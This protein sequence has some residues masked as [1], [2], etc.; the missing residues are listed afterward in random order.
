MKNEAERRSRKGV[1]P[2]AI[3]HAGS[4]P[5][6]A[7]PHFPLCLL[8]FMLPIQQIHGDPLW[9]TVPLSTLVFHIAASAGEEEDDRIALYLKSHSKMGC[10]IDS[11]HPPQHPAIKSLA[12]IRFI[13]TS[14]S[15]VPTITYK[16]FQ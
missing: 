2:A 16:L 10:V 9:S 11:P 13:T 15:P 7:S 3:M 6:F 14:I 5:Q 4:Y 1:N 8:L 12:A